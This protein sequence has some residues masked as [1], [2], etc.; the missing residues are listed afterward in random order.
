MHWGSNLRRL[1]V[2]ISSHC[3]SRCGGCLRNVDGAQTRPGLVL[4]H[5]STDVWQ[6]LAEQTAGTI[7]ELVLN[8][9]WGDPGMHPHLVEM[10]Q[11]WIEHHPTANIFIATNGSMRK[12]AWWKSLGETLSNVPHKI[13]WSIDGIGMDHSL[14][15]RGTSYDDIIANLTAFNAGGGSSEWT[16]TMWD[17]NIDDTERAKNMA[18]VIGCNWFS[19]RENH[20]G[21]KCMMHGN[22]G[23]LQYIIW[24]TKR[25]GKPTERHNLINLRFKDSPIKELHDGT[26]SRCPWYN[27]YRVQIDPFHKV[28]PCCHISSYGHIPG[29]P[30]DG[31]FDLN[32]FPPDK[33]FNDLS[34]HSI[35]DV[36]E[37]EWFN[38]T[39]KS[40]VDNAS[41]D[42][43]KNTCEVHKYS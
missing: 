19:E 27:Q 38:S 14:Y 17:H 30:D 36:L 29:H 32:D 9:N 8:G 13:E 18:T 33:N 3:N 39:I 23:K 25:A 5:F 11:T 40:A 4:S 21:K 31:E 2:D 24:N 42:I 28:W 35:Y 6:T 22:D 12:P 26:H 34:V 1:Q 20:M 16:M 41:W 10:M 37:H 7:E 15:R 43:C